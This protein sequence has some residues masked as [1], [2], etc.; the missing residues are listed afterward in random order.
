MVAV[1]LLPVIKSLDNA[2]HTISIIE[3]SCMSQNARR[4]PMTQS[5]VSTCACQ[6]W[7][8]ARNVERQQR[9]EPHAVYH[10]STGAASR[11]D[12]RTGFRRLDFLPDGLAARSMRRHREKILFSRVR[13]RGGGVSCGRRETSL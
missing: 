5:M 11:I 13:N 10:D 9:Q 6:S 12:Y 3:S 8:R 1:S 4:Q 7:I 2:V